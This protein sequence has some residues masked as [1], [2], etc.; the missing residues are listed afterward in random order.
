MCLEGLEIKLY[1]NLT[2]VLGIYRR[3]ILCHV[4]ADTKAQLSDF[5]LGKKLFQFLS[6]EILK[7]VNKKFK[8]VWIWLLNEC[9][10]FCII[11]LPIMTR[12]YL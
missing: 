4:V 8:K 5:K 1:P 6:Y 12:F 9:K 7:I 10:D 2:C 3:V 11:F